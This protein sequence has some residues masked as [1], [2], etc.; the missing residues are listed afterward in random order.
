MREGKPMR[1][2]V[3]LFVPSTHVESRSTF[4]EITNLFDSKA[5]QPLWI[6]SNGMALFLQFSSGCEYGPFL[7]LK[8]CPW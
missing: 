1:V 2:C 4:L 5:I 8:S 6:N 3:G 7:F